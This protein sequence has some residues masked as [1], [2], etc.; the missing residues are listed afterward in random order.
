V[1]LCTTLVVLHST[2]VPCE[3]AASAAEAESNSDF[4][5]SGIGCTGI[6]GQ[7]V[8]FDDVGDTNVSR[9]SFEGVDAD[10][11]AFSLDALKASVISFDRR[12]VERGAVQT[13][14]NSC[15]CGGEHGDSRCVSVRRSLRQTRTPAIKW[16]NSPNQASPPS[17]QESLS[18]LQYMGASY[19]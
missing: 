5:C 12:T 9:R 6:M 19:S 4:F 7:F 16:S 14:F 10:S 1:L 3:M 18:S 11:G 13:V 17:S 2:F 15:C 8:R